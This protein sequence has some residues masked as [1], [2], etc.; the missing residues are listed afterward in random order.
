LQP[1]EIKE[2]KGILNLKRALEYARIKS[3]DKNLTP[4]Q[5]RERLN[6]KEFSE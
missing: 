1:I 5:I 3:G 2:L 6:K 4:E